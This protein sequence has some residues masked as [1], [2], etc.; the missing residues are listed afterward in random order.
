MFAGSAMAATATGLVAAID[1]T[2][3]PIPITLAKDGG[4]ALNLNV[5]NTIIGTVKKN[6]VVNVTY[7]GST[8]SAISKTATTRGRRYCWPNSFGSITCVN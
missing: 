7:T 1:T 2:K 5:P 6:D 8:V 4:G 3:N